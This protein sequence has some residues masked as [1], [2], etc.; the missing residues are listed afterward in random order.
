MR[1]DAEAL[2]QILHDRRQARDVRGVAGKDVVGDR[3]AVAGDEKADHDLGP[4]AAVVAAV[5]V[6]ERGELSAGRRPGSRSSVD[7]RS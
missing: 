2:L 6:G 5:A 1:A 3:D 4:V 7:V